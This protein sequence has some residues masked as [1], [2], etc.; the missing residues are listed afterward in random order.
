[1]LELYRASAGSGKTYTLARKYIWYFI[2]V[3]PEGEATRL[4]TD[5]EL[6]DSAR[7]ILAV[8]FTN[9]ATNEMQMR[10]VEALFRLATVPPVYRTENGRQVITGP[11][12][13]REFTD[14][15]GV[16]P[17]Q[18]ADIAGKAL[19]VLLENYSDFNV[20][21]IDSFFQLVLRTFAYESE[22]NDSYQVELDGDYVSQV[23]VDATLE[24]VD[25]DDI[26]SEAAFWV[27][28]IMERTEQGKWNIFSNSTSV[29]G[30]SG[31]ASPYADFVSSVRR[32]ENEEYKL[33]RPE[34]ERYLEA[35][36]DLR[37]LYLDL[38]ERYEKPVRL[39]FADMRRA[40]GELYRVLP[41][42]LR[43]ETGR[44]HRGKMVSACKKVLSRE[45]G[46]ILVWNE[47]PESKKIPAL[48]ADDLG[49][50]KMEDWF[51]ENRE[52]EAV[53]RPRAEAAIGA[54]E[55]WKALLCD[56]GFAH[57]RLYSVNL[58]YFALFGIVSRKRREYLDEIN[59]V[60]LAE[61]S[62]I[63]RGVIGDSDAPFVYE[64]LG[65]KL[66]HF[67][68]DEFQDT[69]RLQWDNL[70]PL[71]TESMS[72]NNGNLVIGDAKQSIYRFRNADPS[73]ITSVVPST[74]GDAVETHGDDPSENT[75]Y[76][77]DLRVVQFNNSFFEYLARRLDE[78][79]VRRG[80]HRMRF[81]TLYANVVQ[82]PFRTAPQ[83]YVELRLA[84]D[85]KSAYEAV[86]LGQTV[87][88][89]TELIGRG[90]LQREI[91]VLVR[92][93]AEGE[94]IIRTFVDYNAS[95]A[96]G[97]PEIRFVS[98]QSL[99][100]ASSR[101]VGIITGVLGNMARGS[102]P[103]INEGETARRRGV[104]KWSE[105]M[106]NF[107]Y[108]SIGRMD[109]PVADR[110][111]AFI[112]EGARFDALTDLLSRMQSLA[113]PA[114]VEAIAAAFLPEDL[115]S[116]DAVYI[117]AFQDRVLEYC[118]GHPTDI[119]SFLRWWERKASGASISS[120]EDTDAV[121]VVTVHKSKGLQYRCVIVPF[122][123]WDMADTLP[124]N[125]EEWR[126]VE[127]QVISHDSIPLPPYIPVETSLHMAPTCHGPLLDEY[128][129]MLKMDY[130]NSAYVAL[131]RAERELYVLGVAA[132]APAVV[133]VARGAKA[134][135]G[136]S[137]TTFGNYLFDFIEE[138]SCRTAEGP[139]DP[140]L[141][142][143][144]VMRSD[145]TG[146]VVRIGEPRD[147]VAEGRKTAPHVETIE[148]YSA[149]SSPS[150]LKYRG[151]DMP[152]SPDVPDENDEP[153]LEL[154][155]PRSEGNLKHAVL[156]LVKIP[157][158]LPAAVR[159][160]QITGVIPPAM[161]PAI[162]ESLAGNLKLPQAAHWF[163]GSARVITERPVL[164]RG[165]VSRRPDRVLEYPDGHAEVVDYKF[166]KIDRTGKYKRQISEYVSRL[167][168]TGRYT[169][170]YGFIWYVKENYIQLV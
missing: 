51:R 54:Q 1:M 165:H 68:I 87:R 5:A 85:S 9:K 151:E 142:G 49:L 40:Y 93:N 36:P 3:T 43:K 162:L 111:D 16:S 169:G 62:T 2:T 97:G 145:D 155:D 46:K 167:S 59:A 120:P 20:S 60:E 116:S 168:E 127:P 166:G 128:Y 6:A 159:H 88:I 86:A 140:R 160:L 101:A 22:I 104:G 110:L 15:L 158:D 41:D 69:S 141:A 29:S 100:V 58:P 121:Q 156:E 23:S 39:A 102:K 164:K 8:T 157:S 38:V 64:R 130:L 148:G 42:E 84:G 4:R 71:V 125:R 37:Q 12:Y 150:F 7:H 107:K 153:D 119:A 61:T 78:E 109:I 56:P 134:G 81:S 34:I 33:I 32:L 53:I 95:R 105:L 30:P 144:C 27:Q 152:A 70:R 74:F 19:A 31:S 114:L 139:A 14:A 44:S 48:S 146:L 117:A 65:T 50:K 92:T 91:A 136:A 77:S 83:G 143:D 106:A 99:K 94:N 28:T 103:E 126:W 75:N 96:D 137:A 17:R 10:I 138:V 89:V 79:A 80:D 57:W 47:N 115:R 135:R 52:A 163:D 73:L 11:D 124:A 18:I 25:R 149:V 72:R 131:T 170:V 13:M 66:N 112:R 108:Y 98:E 122:A 21:T 67:L 82:T 55:H 45:K 76:R 154:L 35:T 113:L 90:Y 123:E 118:D 161:A 147:D 26:D 132:K 133:P 63:L 129:D 24:E